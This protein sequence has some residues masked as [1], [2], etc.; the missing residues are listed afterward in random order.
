MASKTCSRYEPDSVVINSSTSYYDKKLEIFTET[1]SE[2]F[3]SDESQTNVIIENCSALHRL[4]CA[5]KYGTT[6]TNEA[7]TEFCISIYKNVLN[8]HVHFMVVH[9]NQIE[10]IHKNLV[11]NNTLGCTLSKCNVFVRHYCTKRRTQKIK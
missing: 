3:G 9:S 4:I 8:D 5:L 1:K 7:F 10:K 6:L 11:H 2:C